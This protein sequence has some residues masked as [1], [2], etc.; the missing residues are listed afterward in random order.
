MESSINLI[1]NRTLSRMVIAGGRPWITGGANRVFHQLAVWR[2]T[3][4]LDHNN[5]WKLGPELPKELYAHCLCPVEVGKQDVFLLHGGLTVNRAYSAGIGL[6]HWSSQAWNVLPD[7]PIPVYGH[8][9]A[10]FSDRSG[11]RMVI[12]AGGIGPGMALSQVIP[13][14]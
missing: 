13:K 7:M 9:C 8:G 2:S 5:E 4:V 14:K 6:F 12:T 11:I 1:E 10:P 3:E